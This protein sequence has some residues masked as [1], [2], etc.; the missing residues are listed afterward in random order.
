MLPERSSTAPVALPEY[1]ISNFETHVKGTYWLT[2]RIPEG[3][4]REEGVKRAIAAAKKLMLITPD[5]VQKKVVE[6]AGKLR[7][8]LPKA[9][10][11]AELVS[12]A[13]TVSLLLMLLA[14]LEELRDGEHGGDVAEALSF[15][16]REEVEFYRHGRSDIEEFRKGLDEQMDRIIRV[17]GEP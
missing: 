14:A 4:F 6:E 2:E 3:R 8:Q 15:G 1:Y 11:P 17:Y 12:H 13:M 10:Q 7:E 9:E 5:E 16:I